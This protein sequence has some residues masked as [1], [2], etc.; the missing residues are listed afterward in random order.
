MRASLGERFRT[1][2][3]IRLAKRVPAG[4]NQ[5]N[6]NEN[7]EDDEQGNKCDNGDEKKNDGSERENHHGP[8]LPRQQ[9]AGRQYFNRYEKRRHQAFFV[10][11]LSLG[12]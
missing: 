12:G 10:V 6:E 11:S 1:N 9:R 2:E 8:L 7:T 4:T 3:R 5:R